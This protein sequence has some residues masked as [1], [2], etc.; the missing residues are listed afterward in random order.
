MSAG[1]S[2]PVD[3]DMHSAAEWPAGRVLVIAAT[4]NE[5]DNLTRLIDGVLS[6]DAEL[7]LLIVDDDSPDGTGQAA[8]AAATENRRVHA[9]VRKGRRGLGTAIMEGLRLA[10][11]HGFVMAINIDADGSHNPDD[12]P[13]LLAAMDP[14]AGPS[15]DVVVGSRRVPGGR[16]VGW[17]WSRHVTSRL[18]GL[19][20]RR[21][22]GVPVCDPSSGYRAIRL[23]LLD[24]LG[25][26]ATSGYAFHEEL[27]W[28]VHRAGG[29]IVEIPMTFRDRT[30][31]ASKA[32]F[33]EI[34]RATGDLLYL[35]KQT[36]LR[37]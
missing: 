26:P 8:L 34:L 1:V 19:F 9:L 7:Q 33:R 30:H 18:V 15:A 28:L 29:R 4:F 6:T 16:T 5:R 13:R 22:L 32:G 10:R 12:I 24:S 23:S 3:G 37:Q 11:E 36:W 25:R 14:V 20:T 35:A 31:G 17:P 27:L 2:A 21:I